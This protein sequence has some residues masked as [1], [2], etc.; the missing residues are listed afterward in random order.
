MADLKMIETGNGG[1]L[2]LSG[3]DLVVIGGLQNMPYLGMFG[4]N[5]EQSTNG[6]K[7]P[8]QQAFDWWGN[9]LLYP[10]QISVQF[11]STLER[12]LKE[13]AL[14]S[15]GRIQIEQAI[16]KDLQFMSDF[17]IVGIETSILANNRIDIN[18]TIQ[19][20][21]NEQSTE[22]TFIWDSTNQELST[23]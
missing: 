6:P 15:S 14:T 1:G 11:N 13:V 7:I 4:G 2:V 19:E 23:T 22:L 10:D 21:N 12:R 5:P 16:Q 3:N 18:L 17:A 9:N 20:P 8:D